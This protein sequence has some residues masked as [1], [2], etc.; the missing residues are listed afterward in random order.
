MLETRRIL[1]GTALVP[2]TLLVTEAGWVMAARTPPRDGWV[3]GGHT[4]SPPARSGMHP[5]SGS[6]ARS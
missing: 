6:Q 2:A 5:A 3:P 4:S 1:R